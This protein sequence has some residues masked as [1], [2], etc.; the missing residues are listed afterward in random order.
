MSAQTTYQRLTDRA[1]HGTPEY[2][3]FL[4]EVVSYAAEG[5]NIGYG[6]VVSLGTDPNKQAVL[7]GAGTGIGITLRELTREG[8]VNT[9]V[10][11]Y[12]EDDTMS[13]LRRGYANIT[14]PTGCVVGDQVEYDDTTGVIDVA[15]FTAGTVTPGA[16]NTGDGVP[17]AATPGQA[18]KVGT[19]RFECI[20]ATVSGSEIFRVT[21]PSGALLADL[22]VAVLY[23]TD[24]FS[25][26]IADGATD[27]VVGDTF[28]MD[29]SLGA[30]KSLLTGA[31]MGY[32]V[33]A[34]EVGIIRR[35][36]ATPLTP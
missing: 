18:A 10:I 22:T 24:Q 31:E 17:G 8:A 27:F 34:G 6:V 29:M 4:R 5:G 16:T 36:G 19:Y 23:T 30:G 35:F 25:L 13:I 2:S 14:I 33:S 3:P 26:T 9:A 32:T 12:Q 1:V 20:D 7:G 15:A 28:T 11:E 21:D